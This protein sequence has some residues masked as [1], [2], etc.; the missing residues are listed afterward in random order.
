[1]FNYK[2]YIIKIEQNLLMEGFVN[3]TMLTY[4]TKLSHRPPRMQIIYSTLTLCKN[5]QIQRQTGYPISISISIPIFSKNQKW[6][7]N[8]RMTRSPSSRK[9]S[10]F[11][12]RMA[13]VRSISLYFQFLWSSYRVNSN[14]F[15]LLSN[16]C[17]T[18]F[19]LGVVLVHAFGV[20]KLCGLERG[21]GFYVNSDLIVLVL[22]AEENIIS[23]SL[24]WL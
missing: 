11:S 14:C 18:L 15:I 1:M 2:D 5:P 9:H 3:S 22:F 7:I 19:Q 8:W 13:M 16:F 4:N 17:A 24:I 10:A 12:T 20:S 23:L 21:F 6:R